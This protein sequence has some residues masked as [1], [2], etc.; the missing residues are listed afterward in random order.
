MSRCGLNLAVNTLHPTDKER[1]RLAWGMNSLAEI[2]D[3]IDSH[4][5]WWRF[6]SE[7]EVRGFLGSDPL[8]IVGEQPSTSEWSPSHPNRRAFYD[9]LPRVGAANAHITDLYK[10]RGRA[11]AL[12]DGLPHDFDLHVELFRNELAILRPTRIIALGH[13]AEALLKRHVPEVR[14]ILT[15]AVPGKL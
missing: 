2:A 4:P 13:D 9:R 7:N 5:D 1:S 11:G 15:R 8:L 14:S 12:R 10:R 6:P 3:F